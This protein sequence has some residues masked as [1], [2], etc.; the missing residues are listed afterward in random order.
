MRVGRWQQ[1]TREIR[2]LRRAEGEVEMGGGGG[3]GG[4]WTWVNEEEGCLRGGG[5]KGGGALGW[6]HGWTI[7]RNCQER[8]DVKRVSF[9]HHNSK[10]I[11]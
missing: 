2:W 4:E 6:W 3:W 9:H 8:K 5:G 1:E 10:I 11:L 7:K